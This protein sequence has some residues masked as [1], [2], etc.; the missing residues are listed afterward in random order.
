MRRCAQARSKNVTRS[1]NAEA[2]ETDKASGPLRF[3]PASWRELTSGRVTEAESKVAAYAAMCADVVK[4]CDF[5]LSFA[6]VIGWGRVGPAGRLCAHV[7]A[8]P[9]PRRASPSPRFRARRHTHPALDT[10]CAL[11]AD[12]ALQSGARA[13]LTEE[14]RKARGT[15]MAWQS[16]KESASLK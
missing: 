5:A 2:Q 15:L 13:V 9:S 7:S 11:C 8:E 10:A 14:Q 12:L 1:D 6:P 16:T 4:R 3:P